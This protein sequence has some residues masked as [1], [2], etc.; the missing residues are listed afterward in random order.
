MPKEA[1]DSLPGSLKKFVA[2]DGT[3][4]V[5]KFGQSYLQAEQQIS[6]LSAQQQPTGP[7]PNSPEGKLSI[8]GRTT[9]VSPDQTMEQVLM[10]VGL[11]EQG[12]L[13]EYIAGD[14]KLNDETYTKLQSKFPRAMV[15]MFL[16]GQS[17]VHQQAQFAAQAALNSAQQAAGG[18][19]QLQSLLSWAGSSG[20]FTEA[21]LDSLDAQVKNPQL[22]LAA[23][24]TMKARHQ[25]ALGAGNAQPLVQ[26]VGGGGGTGLSITRANYHEVSAR[27]QGGDPVA[28]QALQ[29]AQQ[30]GD[31]HKIFL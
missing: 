14:G 21:E 1:L 31:L 23:V 24:D 5:T 10:E 29:E 22:V 8:K 4:D 15:D 11:T 9:S 17:A 30:R 20:S 7:D 28:A 2:D 27:A 12:V 3:L 25:Q 26:G 19:Q 16:K 6:K 18:E 13:D